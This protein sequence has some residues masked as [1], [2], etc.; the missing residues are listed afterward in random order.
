MQ[1]Y[2]HYPRRC[3]ERET[4]IFD[5]FQYNKSNRRGK[6]SRWL[7]INNCMCNNTSS[8]SSFGR[9]LKIGTAIG[10]LCAMHNLGRGGLRLD[11]IFIP[12]TSWSKWESVWYR[13]YREIKCQGTKQSEIMLS[14]KIITETWVIVIIVYAIIVVWPH[15][16]SNWTVESVHFKEY[17]GIGISRFNWVIFIE[18]LI[19]WGMLSWLK[20]DENKTN[21]KLGGDSYKT[22]S[23]TIGFARCNLSYLM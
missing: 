9:W 15:I 16:F 1:R 10:R 17:I 23:L 3:T 12:I 21:G 4:W 20:N 13:L 22:S 19:W 5:L 11:A 14:R 2:Q 6:L 8:I 18:W 7:V